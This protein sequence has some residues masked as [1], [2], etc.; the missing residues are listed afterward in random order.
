MPVLARIQQFSGT[1]TDSTIFRY[2][3]GQFFGTRTDSTFCRYSPGFS[4]V[5]IHT[6]ILPFLRTGP[7]SFSVLARIP[8]FASTRPDSAM[9]R[10]THSF[11]HFSVLF[12]T[13]FRY[14]YGFHLLRVLSRIQ[15]CFET[16]THSIIFPYWS[17]L[18]FGTRTVS[19]FYP[20]SPGF[21]NFPML[22]LILPFSVLVRTVLRYS[23]EFHLL[24]V[25]ARIQHFFGTHTDS[26]IFSYWSGQFFGTNTDSTFCQYS[27]GFSN[28]PVLTLILLF[29]CTGLNNFSVVA[30]IPP[31][32]GTGPD[33]TIFRYSH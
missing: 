11:Y 10:D 3:S 27:P 9:F 29:F 4:N 19:T 33:S 31:F 15:Q 20:Y 24:P 2:W 30:R 26:T 23:H 22:T 14:S 5:P 28:V 7:N 16:H 25:L 17:E 8:P 13:V 6:L 32:T 18:F 1:H 21:N 12:R